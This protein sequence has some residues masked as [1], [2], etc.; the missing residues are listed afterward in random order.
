MSSLKM[1]IT[2]MSCGHCVAAVSRSLE[3][4]DGVHSAQVEI[5]AATVEFDADRVTP[6][7]L[8]QAVADEGYVVVGTH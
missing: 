7:Q 3:A 4:I 2:G 6:R 8:E 1:D 5:G